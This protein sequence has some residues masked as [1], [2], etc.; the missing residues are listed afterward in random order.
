[1]TYRP[2]AASARRLGA[3]A[4]VVA[5][6]VLLVPAAPAAAMSPYQFD[7]AVD[8]APP[9]GPP[10]PEFPMKQTYL[11]ATTGRLQDSQFDS[12][13]ID[14]V[15][16]VRRLHG[17]A[18]GKGQTVAVI[19][20]GVSRNDRLP[21]LLGGGDYILGEDGLF[22]CDHHGTLVA[23]VIAA[24]ARPGDGFVGIAPDAAIVSIRQ[25]SSRY[26]VE[27]AK[28]SNA[29]EAK[30]AANLTT[31]ARA[32]VH[33]ASLNATVINISATACVPANAN[34]DLHPLA[35][36]LYYAA[37]V[38]DAVVVT[39]AG[40]LAGDL[41][42]DCAPTEGPDPATP[43]DYRGWGSAEVMSLPSLFTDFVLSVGGSTLRGEPY[44]YSMP[45]PWVGVAAP[46]V[47]VVSL[48]PSKITGELVNSQ[49]TKDG[50]DA[51]A[52][53]SFSSANV[54]G[55]AALIRQRYPQLSAHQVIERIKRTAH[56]PS[57]AVS[58]LL[59]SGIVDPLAALTAPIDDSIP[60]VADNIPAVAAIP[61][62]PPPLP[63]ML[64]RNIALITLGVLAAAVFVTV[65]ISVARG[66]RAPK[67]S[68]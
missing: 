57:Q 44:P 31:L 24:A 5:A 46:A 62:A 6:V 35:G 9:D 14:T 48:D 32:I 63:D 68:S 22:D 28:T 17:F 37:V 60:V 64:G 10:G 11:C 45:G 49:E 41:G 50:P 58:S 2:I 30:A 55:L 3:L 53:T 56:T 8:I 18:T 61:A 54:S 4:A 38:K 7:P 12:I 13:P 34:V 1:M 29:Q 65:M 25:A 51:I 23:G 20:S 43:K 42:S 21:Q 66:G 36:A 59:G 52:G 67:E 33:A 15:W 40:N 16:E 39:A 26:E 19:D 27:P 47:N